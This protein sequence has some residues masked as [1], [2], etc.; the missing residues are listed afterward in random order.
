MQAVRVLCVWRMLLLW[1]VLPTG[2][3]TFTHLGRLHYT[4]REISKRAG[5]LI[6]EINRK[7]RCAE[8]S[9]LEFI[10]SVDSFKLLFAEF[11][12]DVSVS[13]FFIKLFNCYQH[14]EELE[15]LVKKK[16]F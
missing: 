5:R 11:A 16:I 1:R 10:E 4:H 14:F 6:Y 12:V 7:L 8:E 3:R 2:K 9:E 13:M 15:I